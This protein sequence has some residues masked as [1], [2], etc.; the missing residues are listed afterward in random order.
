MVANEPDH[1][2]RDEALEEVGALDGVVAGAEGLADVVQQR[3][4]D[5]GRVAALAAGMLEHLEGVI[6]GVALGV[7][8][9]VLRDAV[10]GDEEVEEVGVHGGGRRERWAAPLTHGVWSH[11][12]GEIG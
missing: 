12:L 11:P 1:P 6:E 10:E 9:R 5:E 4:R 7:V 8:P 3:S 2:G